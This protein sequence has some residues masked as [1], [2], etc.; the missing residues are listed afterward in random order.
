MKLKFIPQSTL[1]SILAAVGMQIIA[2]L[3]TRL[4][5]T[6]FFHYNLES[7]WDLA[8]PFLPWMV[9]IYIGS[10]LFWIVNVLVGCNVNPEKFNRIACAD[11]IA[12]FLSA[13]TFILF[14]TTNTR[15]DPGSGFWGACMAL[16][17]QVD[18]ADNLFPSLHCMLS[19]FCYLLVKGEAKVPKWYRVFS[20][21]FCFAIF[22]STM[23]TKQHILLDVLGGWFLAVSCNRLS[24]HPK[25]YRT[26]AR[27]LGI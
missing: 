5:S 14:P 25:V 8:F 9:T 13:L 6:G 1:R 21:L 27:I 20:L 24:K 10:F 23:A 15:P 18:P 16:V 4:V 17:Y 19:W 2:Y 11:V 7:A 22:I 3:G 26:Y 12:L